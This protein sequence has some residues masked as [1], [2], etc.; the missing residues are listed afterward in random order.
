MTKRRKI[1]EALANLFKNTLTGEQPYTGPNPQAIISKRFLAPV[2]H[3]RAMRDVPEALYQA[4]V[5][6]LARTREKLQE[7]ERRL[8]DLESR[9]D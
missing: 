5:R 1:T 7:L 8:A 6:V 4:V 2:P 3:V 9:R